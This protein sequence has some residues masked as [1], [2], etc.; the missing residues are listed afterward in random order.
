M[1]PDSAVHGAIP[2]SKKQAAGC[3]DHRAA[4]NVSTSTRG[5]HRE[6][7]RDEPSQRDAPARTEIP[8]VVVDG[9]LP[10]GLDLEDRAAMHDWLR[11][12]R[13]LRDRA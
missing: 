13:D 11:S 3:W 7:S 10:P 6:L 8:W 4:A 12:R 5:L 2:R 9:G 1:K